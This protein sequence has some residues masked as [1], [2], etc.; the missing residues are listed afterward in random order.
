[1]KNDSFAKK[2]YSEIRKK[3]LSGQILPNTRLKEDAWAQKLEIGRMSI[4]EALTRLLGEGLLV[5]GEKG[6]YFVAGL[7]MEDIEEIRSLRQILE[8]GALELSIQRIT[9]TELAVLDQICEDFTTMSQQGYLAGACEAD[10]KFH[11]ALLECSGNSKLISI[12]RMSHIP[13]F[14]AKLGKTA[15]FMDDYKETD[16]EHRMIIQA[17]KNKDFDLAKKTMIQHFKRGSTAI[18]DL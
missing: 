17:V 14:H 3:I 11:E 4:R 13:L 1:M 2:A 9:D 8:I 15:V 16:T 12:Y 10:I 5:E 18:L 7:T 6:G